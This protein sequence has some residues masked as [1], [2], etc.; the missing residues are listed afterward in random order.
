MKKKLTRNI[1]VKILSVILAALLW[2]LI[3]NVDDPVKTQLFANIPVRILNEDVVDSPNKV[4]EIVEG[5]NITFRVAARRSILEEL[6]KDD[7]NVTADFAKLLNGNTVM[8]DISPRRF[9]NEVSITDGKYQTL[10]IKFEEIS[11]EDFKVNVVPLGKVAEGYHIA[12]KFASPNII[13]VT[14]PKGRIDKIKEVVAEVNVEG[15]SRSFFDISMPKALDE[16]GKEI[17]SSK[18]SFST[19]YPEVNVKLYKTKTVD[20]KVVTE[21][22]PANGFIMTGI[23]YE[24]KTVT[25]AAE[26]DVLRD[27]SF[28][29]LTQSI[30]GESEDI[31]RDVDLR[32]ELKLKKGVILVED[33]PTV[34]INIKLEKLETK[35]IT[36]WPNDIEIRNN[37]ESLFPTFHTIGPIRVNVMGLEKEIDTLTRNT[38][39]SYID[40]TDFSIG[41][42]VLPLKAELPLNT[43][44]TETPM[45]SITLTP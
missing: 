44:L 37:R 26:D 12:E 39:E 29:E 32:D 33:N 31:E 28:L 35:E 1:G 40:L 4:Y 21:G 3:T 5:E 45:I 20:L 8:I 19:R 16:E 10:T 6:S 13:R 15:V 18:L 25:I 11:E 17:D 34:S 30:E 43:I 14:G 23:D 22:Q 2:L 42:Y 7:F 9:A 27:I 24:P 36:I 38:L 41:T